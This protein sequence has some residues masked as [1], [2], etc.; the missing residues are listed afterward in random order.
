MDDLLIHNVWMI[1]VNQAYEIIA[2]SVSN[3]PMP[4]PL[5]AGNLLTPGKDPNS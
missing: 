3:D 1:T 4:H 5:P 2:I